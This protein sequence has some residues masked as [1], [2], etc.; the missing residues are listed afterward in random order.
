[1][2][3]VGGDATGILNMIKKKD[4]KAQ[5]TSRF[6]HGYMVCDKYARSNIVNIFKWWR[7]MTMDITNHMANHVEFPQ[8][9]NLFVQVFKK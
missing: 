5:I 7:F 3:H 1:M 9:S 2:A 6:R 4:S 8:K